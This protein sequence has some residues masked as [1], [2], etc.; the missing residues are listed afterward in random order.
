MDNWESLQSNENKPSLG[1]NTLS[2]SREI[3]WRVPK[4]T[5]EDIDWE[6][7]SCELQVK[8]SQ[9]PESDPLLLSFY[10]Q[11]DNWKGDEDWAN[12]IYYFDLEHSEI[13]SVRTHVKRAIKKALAQTGGKAPRDVRE[14]GK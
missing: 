8:V 11:V 13:D 6:D 3:Y 9:G 2:K 10:P 7:E 14:S 12:G 4:Y 5:G 1:Q